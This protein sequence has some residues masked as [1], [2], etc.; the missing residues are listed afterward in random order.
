MDRKEPI[1][2]GNSGFWDEAKLGKEFPE[3]LLPCAAPFLTT[4]AAARSPVAL[5]LA[6]RVC[7]PMAAL[8]SCLDLEEQT[9][10]LCEALNSTTSSRALALLFQS[11]SDELRCFQ[12]LCRQPFT[13]EAFECYVASVQHPRSD[14]QILA[15][16]RLKLTAW[17][18]SM[19]EIVLAQTLDIALKTPR[20]IGH[21]SSPHIRRPFAGCLWGAFRGSQLCAAASLSSSARALRVKRGQTYIVP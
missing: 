1:A 3:H 16:Q 6:E 15:A 8:P 18:P 2:Q 19:A 21:G 17:E 12:L 13:K 11:C 14:I 5:E 9:L 7:I 20:G 4:L 10:D